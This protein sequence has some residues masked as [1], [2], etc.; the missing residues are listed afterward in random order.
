MKRLI[1]SRKMGATVLLASIL[2][3]TGCS[4]QDPATESAPAEETS[5]AAQSEGAEAGRPTSPG[6][7]AEEQSGEKPTTPDGINQALLAAAHLGSTQVPEG[8]VVEVESEEHGDIWEVK[9]IGSDGT[10]YKMDTTAD[11]KRL[12]GDLKPRDTSLEKRERNI[13][14]LAQLKVSLE[15]A[16][17]I[18]LDVHPDATFREVELDTD[19][20]VLNWGATVVLE[21]G[22]KQE[23][24]V[25]VRTGELL[26]DTE[27]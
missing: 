16:V 17:G 27:D 13:D 9:V 19:N 2:V 8:V 18:I 14:R 22:T 11:G 25:D 12:M 23:I 10:A 26:A 5:Q 21:D 1:P 15:E 3:L 6:I 20:D 7:H 24:R 4:T